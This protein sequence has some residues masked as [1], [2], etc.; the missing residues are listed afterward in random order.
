MR[1]NDSLSVSM[2]LT[3]M[4]QSQ[5]NKPSYVACVGSIGRWSKANGNQQG[6]IFWSGL[7]EPSGSEPGY[8]H[9]HVITE[10]NVF[11]RSRIN[12]VVVCALT[13]QSET[14]HGVRPCTPRTWRGQSAPAKCGAYLADFHRGQIS[15]GRQDGYAFGQA[16]A[17]H[18]Q[19]H[20]TA[21]RTT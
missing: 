6:D 18:F 17:Q 14:C 8:R 19:R 4:Y 9:P 1:I 20:S 15:V 10:N 11:N 16:C 7:D 21:H 3:P 2:P 13:L 12:T 5:T